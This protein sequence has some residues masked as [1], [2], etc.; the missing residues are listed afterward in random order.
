MSRAAAI[1]S[2]LLWA[3]WASAAAAARFDVAALLGDW[4]V[5]PEACA[6]ARLSYEAEGLH[7]A[8]MLDQSGQW[9]EVDRARYA[10][11]GRELVIRASGEPEHRLPVASLDDERLVFAIDAALAAEIGTDEIVL[12]RCPPR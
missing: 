4:A 9:E 10:L 12:F 2:V 8:W 3:M 7:R 1:G 11:E 6:S 5:E